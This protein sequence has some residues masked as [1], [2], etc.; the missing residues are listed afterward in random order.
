MY[1]S[2][3][4]SKKYALCTDS[5]TLSER[6]TQWGLTAE[7]FLYGA[8]CLLLH[9][10]TEYHTFVL[11]YAS[12]AGI[13]SVLVQID[14][15]A[16]ALDAVRKTLDAR[17][18]ATG[19]HQEPTGRSYAAL[20]GGSNSGVLLE[21]A[22]A[23]GHIAAMTA[24]ESEPGQPHTMRYLYDEGAFTDDEIRIQ[25]KQLETVIADVL[26]NPEKPVR[27]LRIVSDHE[28]AL[29]RQANE[30]VFPYS[31]DK[32]IHELLEDTATRLPEAPALGFRDQELSY[33]IFNRKAN[34]LAHSLRARG[35]GPGSFVA[36]AAERSPELIIAMFA[37]LKTGAAFI[38]LSL[39]YPPE[40]LGLILRHANVKLLLTTAPAAVT[41]VTDGIGVAALD[42]NTEE[43]YTVNPQS[44]KSQTTD[45]SQTSDTNLP[46]AAE[47]SPQ[48]PAALI[49]TS[50]TTGRPKGVV[51]RHDTV[52]NYCEF[53]LREFHISE[54]DRIMQFAP[55][56][57]STAILEITTTLISGAKL[58]LVPEPAVMDPG[59]F[60]Q[61]MLT[62]AA[63]ILLAPPEYIGYLPLP[64]TLHIVETG[65][66]ECKR[67]I[68]EKIV[69]TALHAN[70]YGLTEGCVPTV[71]KGREGPRPRRI[72]IGKP[73]PNTQVYILDSHGESCGLYMPGELCVT[74]LSV[75]NGYLGD[76][77]RTAE[78]FVPNPFGAGVMLRTGDIAQWSAD[79]NIE[80]LG[81]AD[82]QIQIRGM[83]VELE[84]VERALAQMPGV[85]G[86]AA[87]SR[88]APNGDAQIVAFVT[89][90]RGAD[91]T[92]APLDP[93]AIR[94]ELYNRLLEHKVPSV[95]VPL[96]KLP[97]T[98]N[99]K[100]DKGALTAL[101][102]AAGEYTE[103]LSREE[104]LVVRAFEET[105]GLTGIGTQA[106]FFALGGH[107]LRAARA[108]NLVEELSGIRL[109]LWQW[110]ETPTVEGLAAVLKESQ[111][112]QNDT[113]TI[114]RYTPIPRATP[115]EV[116]PMSPA[117]RRLYLACQTDD[118]G[119]AY[120]IP[121]ALE[122]A[123]APDTARMQA[124]L[125]A[126][127]QRQE[128]FR[129]SFH[130]QTSPNNTFVQ[131]IAP[132]GQAPISLDVVP[133]ALSDTPASLLAGF[134]R[135]FDLAKAP[136]LRAQAA[137]APDG[138][139]SVLLF[140]LHH[141]IADGTTM[142]LLL[143][144]FEALYN[145]GALSPEDK[146]LPE[147]PLQYKDF[148]EWAR[149]RDLSAQ[150][151]HWLSVFADPA[152][153]LNLITD[154]PRRRR[155]CVGGEKTAVIDVPLR[156]KIEALAAAHGATPYMVMLANLAVMLA[157]YTRQED[158]TIGTPAAG[159]VH[160]DLER[161]AGMFVNTVALRSRPVRNKQFSEFLRE[162]RLS[163]LLAFENQ[164]YPFEEL[165]EALAL[166]QDPTRNPLFDVMLIMQNTEPFTV[167]P[168][169]LRFIQTV[170]NPESAKFD[171]T[172]DITERPNGY[173]V[174]LIYSAALY[175]PES[176]E[177]MLRHYLA[178]L[179]AAT[180]APAKTIG[181]LSLANQ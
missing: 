140:D 167:N 132:P 37:V 146:P 86:A 73:V 173:H 142:Y 34:R 174:K 164:E 7:N 102:I 129:T 99:G 158:I 163:C 130:T 159:R 23:A 61:E 30:T 92:P 57:F 128:V 119:T 150:K 177:A 3:V 81:R 11:G 123:G 65:A 101:D 100:I 141:I 91:N 103:P 76:P 44:D 58:C 96:E 153:T 66:S 104:E 160:Q 176:A 69:Q 59:A 113:N 53:N 97:M 156:G 5:S 21:E 15:N 14:H 2:H 88:P 68:S 70:A 143:A 64:P 136:L 121:V 148:S 124:A 9:R 165:T 118:T 161:I 180:A 17:D 107:S 151:A 162:I 79:G 36:I 45:E 54:K 157:K 48:S 110:F 19:A 179:D 1:L 77:E 95:V 114:P 83:R 18:A 122:F 172:F 106:N 6:C 10:K 144:D 125:T 127:S 94:L 117:Q 138:S 27:S 55:F 49:Y 8:Y 35:A 126:L 22:L 50:G 84:E 29:I 178:L 105:L 4:S 175:R 116:Y 87:L 171:L 24:P 134:V 71:W 63:T 181:D 28:R 120:N 72:P 93:N 85:A 41:P 149:T 16:S 80:Y 133:Y 111:Q 89:P 13:R 47:F 145:K 43:T 169:G 40:F 12:G 26:A 131:R 139:R 147:P 33:D 60:Y 154:F 25:H 78:R 112:T 31:D 74:G 46:R 137:V 39:R 90:A 170:I 32:C 67:E 75:S 51:V 62:A 168:E 52:V 135:P 98:P 42:L 108:A 56:T 115:Q 166:P 109:P 155:S 20:F 82:N 152:P 38:P